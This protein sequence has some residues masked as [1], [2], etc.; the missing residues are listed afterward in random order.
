MHVQ[1]PVLVYISSKGGQPSSAF[2]VLALRV[3]DRE[4]LQCDGGCKQ[5]SEERGGRSSIALG[6]GCPSNNLRP[7]YVERAH[8][9]SAE[10]GRDGGRERARRRRL[11]DARQHSDLDGAEALGLGLGLGALHVLVRDDG[12]AA[13]PLRRH[14]LGVGLDARADGRLVQR[15]VRAERDGQV[16][17][18]PSGGVLGERVSV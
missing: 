11:G 13:R 16:G 5:S 2:P 18:R 10:R 3:A 15:E 6:S 9:G 14:R 12:G 4:L 17:V 7:T 1:T 8:G